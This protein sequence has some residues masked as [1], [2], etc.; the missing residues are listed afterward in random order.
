VDIYALRIGNVIEPHEYE[1]DFPSYIDMPESRKRN[2]WSY[3]DARDL[4]QIC[5][6][7]IK[8]NGL[9]FQVFNAT[10]DTITVKGELHPT[11]RILEMLE[12]LVTN[13]VQKGTTKEFLARNCPGT[14][15]TREMEEFEAPLSNKKI[16]DVLG[17]K[18]VH[19]WRKY[20]TV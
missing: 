19:N 20:V 5:D 15:V 14:K 7:A 3:I 9:G 13:T 11:T 12:E 16:R 6:L 4:G 1:R 2:A 8:K 10:N 17:F 18:D